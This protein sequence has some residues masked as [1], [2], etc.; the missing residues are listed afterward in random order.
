MAISFLDCCVEDCN[1]AEVKPL[2]NA[3]L[4]TTLEPLTIQEVS[5]YIIYMSVGPLKRKKGTHWWLNLF[6]IGG[7]ITVSRLLV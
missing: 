1:K 7:F 5:P 3:S 4:M 6:Q 2:G